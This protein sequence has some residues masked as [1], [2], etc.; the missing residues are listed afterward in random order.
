MTPAED[1]DYSEDTL[2]EQP[3]IALFQEL[4]WA[5]ANCF[6][7]FDQPGGSRLG[8]ENK[9]QGV[10]ESRLRPVLERLNPGLPAMAY[11]QAIE[12]ITRDRSI[13]SP[14]QANRDVYKLLKDGVKVKAPDSSGVEVTAVD[15][16][17]TICT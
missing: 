15:G 13:M 16:S 7:E 12:E 17:G 1:S 8:R 3:A 4:G 10:L 9:G 5:T 2:V 11:Q 14:A 6:Y